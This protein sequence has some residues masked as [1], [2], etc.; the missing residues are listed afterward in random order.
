MSR[1]VKRADRKRVEDVSL[2]IDGKEYVLHDMSKTGFSFKIDDPNDFSIGEIL[3][4][5]MVSDDGRED[6]QGKIIHITST[7]HENY[8]VG[9]EFIGG[10]A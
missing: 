4:L 3:T 9:L 8:I 6:L 10:G 2:H 7:V 5:E 1:E